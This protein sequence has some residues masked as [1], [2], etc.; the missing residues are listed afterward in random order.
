MKKFGI[1]AV[2]ASGL[3]AAILGLASPA[4]ANTDTTTDPIVP[5]TENVSHGIGHRPWL[6]IV[7]PDASVPRVG[8]GLR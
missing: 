5:T 1:A 7:R 2:T 6:D 8:P 4:Q 3:A